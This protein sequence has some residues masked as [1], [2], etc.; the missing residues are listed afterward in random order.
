MKSMRLLRFVKFGSRIPPREL[1]SSMLS[2]SIYILFFISLN[3]YKYALTL[4]ILNHF[5]L[6]SCVSF[7][8]I[9][10]SDSDNKILRSNPR[11]LGSNQTNGQT[12]SLL[13][14]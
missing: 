2:S 5:C 11:P 6:E 12:T 13:D 10:D 1:E 3:Y 8:F 14:F 4:H 7:S 9:A